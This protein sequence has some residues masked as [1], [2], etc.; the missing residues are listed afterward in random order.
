MG[1]LQHAN[2]KGTPVT[3]NNRV[4]QNDGIPD[5]G[6][7]PRRTDQRTSVNRFHRFRNLHILVYISLEAS[8]FVSSLRNG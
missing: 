7:S 4:L 3:A 8:V 2:R 1:S 5:A 6:Q